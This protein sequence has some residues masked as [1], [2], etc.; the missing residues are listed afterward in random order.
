MELYW[1]I[2]HI[3]DTPHI[4]H[5]NPILVKFY[6][7]GNQRVRKNRSCE[8]VLANSL[9]NWKIYYLKNCK[10][11]CRSYFNKITFNKIFK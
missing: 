8:L 1:P 2:L 7:I 4:I 5:Q 9:E 11:Y 10:R 6:V 3:L